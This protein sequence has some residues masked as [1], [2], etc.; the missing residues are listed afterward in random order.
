MLNGS[1]L[2]TRFAALAST[3][4]EHVLPGRGA[5]AA[6]GRNLGSFLPVVVAI[7]LV[8]LLVIVGTIVFVRRKRALS[9]ETPGEQRALTFANARSGYGQPY[10]SGMLIPRDESWPWARQIAPPVGYNPTTP[11][12]DALMMPAAPMMPG[13]PAYPAISMMPVAE[14]SR[15]PVSPVTPLPEVPV[16]ASLVAARPE[17]PV[18]AS[19][20]AARPVAIE[21]PLQPPPVPMPDAELEAIMRQVQVGLFALPVRNTC[22]GDHVLDQSALYGRSS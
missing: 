9:W 1:G 6:S 4:M 22:T 12:P 8:M 20:V 3:R 16:G 7:M 13:E 15:T 14:P 11:I 17:V 2:A 19:L 10:S 5:L 21:N 18:G